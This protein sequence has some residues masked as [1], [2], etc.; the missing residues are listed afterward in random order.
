MRDLLAEQM[1]VF[2]RPLHRWSAERK[3]GWMA[4][5]APNPFV[6]PN[7]VLKQGVKLGSTGRPTTHDRVAVFSA[8][9][10]A[11][12]ITA[13]LLRSDP[14]TVAAIR[15]FAKGPSRSCSRIPR[16]TKS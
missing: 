8:T 7:A 13:Q 3:G 6:G 2:R 1:A 4:L 15:P 10:L 12:E 16:Q 11:G 9:M 5:K 14:I